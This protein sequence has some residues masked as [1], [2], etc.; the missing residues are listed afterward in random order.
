[1]AKLSI[2]ITGK[3]RSGLFL[4]SALDQQGPTVAALV[5][6]KFRASLPEG[7]EPPDLTSQITTLAR[8][9]Q[10]VLDEMVEGDLALYRQSTLRAALLKDR[11]FKVAELGRKVIGVR[12]I[13]TGYYREPDVGQLGLVGETAREPVALIRQTDLISQQLK[14]EKL[15]EMLG[16]A[17]FE[18]AYDP[19]PHV[20]QIEADLGA[21]RLAYETHQRS[22]R[23]VDE[24]LAHKKKAV[25]DFETVFVRVARQFEDLCRLAGEDDLAD[26]VRPSL[27]RK[28]ETVVPPPEEGASEAEEGESTAAADDGAS[29]E[30]GSVSEPAEETGATP[31]PEPASEPASA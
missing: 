27:N 22:R 12:R 13:I 4:L 3:N 21:V 29:S 25:E 5:A 31:D 23:R 28:G 16:E 24:M 2:E 6:E 11:D 15:G 17:L 19:S 18:P 10:T 9:L 20:A 1:M 7:E 8:M 30:G 14:S 26:K